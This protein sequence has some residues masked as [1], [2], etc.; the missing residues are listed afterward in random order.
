MFGY[1]G[2]VAEIANRYDSPNRLGFVSPSVQLSGRHTCCLDET[3]RTVQTRRMLTSPVGAF[4]DCRLL[5]EIISHAVR[6]DYF[7]GLVIPNVEDILSHLSIEA[8]R[9]A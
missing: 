1:D 8:S 3:I 2:F 4:K 9:Q 7:F 6:L 5:C